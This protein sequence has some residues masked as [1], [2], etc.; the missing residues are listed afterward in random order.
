[1]NARNASMKTYLL[2]IALITYP[3]FI[4]AQQTINASIMHNGLERDYILYV[5]SNHYTS[6]NV[7]LILNFHGYTSNAYEQMFYGDFRSIA[8]TAGFIIAHPQGTADNLN[9]NHWNVGWQA[10]TVDDIGF[11]DHLIDTIASMFSIDLNRVYSTG[12]SNG[13]FMSYQLA[14]ELSNRIAAIASVTG[15]M[16]PYKLSSCQAQHPTPV[17]QIHGTSDGV[18]AYNGT[19]FSLHIDSTVKYWVDYNNCDQTAIVTN[20]P[21]I[22]LWDGSTATH[23]AYNNGDNRVSVELF[24]IDMGGHTWP[25]SLFAG[26]GTNQDIRA[27][28]E[29][30]KFFSKYDINGVIASSSAK[31]LNKK[32]RIY[33]NPTKDYIIIENNNAINNN[34]ILCD[35]N[36]KVIASETFSNG[37]FMYDVSNLKPGVYFIKINGFFEKLIK[38]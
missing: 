25:G 6:N 27:S 34:Y 22:S 32:V 15:S 26:T 17:M 2:L 23:Y 37:T 10:S 18:V 29:I 8:D 14:C 30:W 28:E 13:G 38:Y 1:M 5:P 12:M 7:P 24:K 35:L 3:V 21:N 20:M 16:N 19:N 4:S 31:G 9:N 11:I 33:P 36:G